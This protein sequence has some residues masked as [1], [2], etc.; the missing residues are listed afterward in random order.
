MLSF[1]SLALELLTDD[2][3]SQVYM[4][5]SSRQNCK[6][7]AVS[8]AV[9]SLSGHA[10]ARGLR[11]WFEREFATEVPHI[12]ETARFGYGVAFIDDVHCLS[13]GCADGSSTQLN[14]ADELLRGLL[15]GH[16][17]FGITRTASVRNPVS[18]GYHLGSDDGAFTACADSAPILHKEGFTDI[19]MQL[20]TSDDFMMQHLGIVTA[21]TGQYTDL[22]RQPWLKALAANFALVSL[23][24]FQTSELNVALIT[25]AITSMSTVMKDFHLLEL[26]QSEVADLSRITLNV[27][28]RMVSSADLLLT[29]S[30]ER[31]VRSM[32]SLDTSLVSKFCLSLRYGSEHVKNPGGLLQLYVHE[33]KRY[34]L[35]PLPQGAQRDRVIT[36]LTEYMDNLD[37]KTW[38][39]SHDWMKDLKDELLAN[40]DRVWTNANVFKSAL[41]LDITGEDYHIEAANEKYLPMS[42][43]VSSTDRYLRSGAWNPT[44]KL[45]DEEQTMAAIIGTD[46][47]SHTTQRSITVEDGISDIDVKCVMYPAALTLLLRMVRILSVAG[48]H[49]IIAGY[50]GSSKMTAVLLAAKICH[51]QSRHYVAKESQSATDT[52]CE[53]A[54]QAFDF[55][56]FIKRAVLRVAGFSNPIVAEDFENGAD[57]FATSHGVLLPGQVYYDALPSEKVVIVVDEAQQLNTEARK[58]MLHLLDYSDPSG[59]FDDSELQ[60]ES[61]TKRVCCVI[62]CVSNAIAQEWWMHCE[63]HQNFNATMTCSCLI[64]QLSKSS[65]QLQRYFNHHI[66]RS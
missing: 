20:H 66:C 60:G 49:M 40:V 5:G 28:M 45:F 57:M 22:C 55:K 26:L 59:L 53:R 32:I 11:G 38:S 37:E 25:G 18:L 61:C 17:I 62:V 16:P 50:P 34:L 6:A 7:R 58:W 19:R 54:A 47:E 9:T 24:A 64:H 13:D 3:F 30:L 48:K 2:L 14:L 56:L 15:D 44:T 21:A 1:F 42:L 41:R 12:L 43:D 27:C 35:D 52:C 39:I 36:L 29:T 4:S 46:N 10:G 33:W 23:P 31:T 63:D 8:S 65:H 51:L